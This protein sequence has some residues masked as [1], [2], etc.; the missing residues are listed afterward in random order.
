MKT[1]M[2][3]NTDRNLKI[4]NRYA[5]EIKDFCGWL[6]ITGPEKEIKRLANKLKV[7]L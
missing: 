2:A 4:A 1:M 5:V 7:L 3:E 6:Y